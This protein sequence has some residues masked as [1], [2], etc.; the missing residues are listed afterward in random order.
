[1]LPAPYPTANLAVTEHGTPGSAL[2]V[3]HVSAAVLADAPAASRQH[4][5][6][7]RTSGRTNGFIGPSFITI[8][9]LDIEFR[10][11]MP[12]AG[13]PSELPTG[14]DRASYGCASSSDF[15]D[16]ASRASRA[17]L[18]DFLRMVITAAHGVAVA[19]YCLGAF[20]AARPGAVGSREMTIV[21]F[22][23]GVLRYLLLVSDGQGAAPEE[24]LFGDRFMQ[25]TGLA[26]LLSLA[27]G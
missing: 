21:P 9:R 5:I 22:T 13:V 7:A 17:A 11:R 16:P 4:P 10:L 2:V 1:M 15:L 3:V 25:L 18:A 12:P 24:I 27:L 14:D 19:A 23:F 8:T 20:E 26:W 6:Q